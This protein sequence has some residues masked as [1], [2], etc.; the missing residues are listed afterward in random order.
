MSQRII[1][2]GFM[3]VAERFD[4][5]RR[6]AAQLRGRD[7]ARAVV[8]LDRVKDT[9][10]TARRCWIDGAARGAEIGATHHLL[11]QDDALL[12]LDFMDGVRNALDN[13]PEHAVYFYCGRGECEE[14]QAKGLSWVSLPEVMSAVAVCIPTPWIAEFLAWDRDHAHEIEPRWRKHDDWR[15]ARFLKATGRRAWATVPSLVEHGGV[16]HSVMGHPGSIGGR[17]RMAKVWI[18][19]DV[20]AA[21]I[22]FSKGAPTPAFPPTPPQENA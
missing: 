6:T 22:D 12:C 5:V 21:S 19:D 2:I 1:T 3:A 8:T 18:G 4:M 16:N 7:F 15:L 10:D 13:A 20:S 14:A 11:L 17:P 9:W